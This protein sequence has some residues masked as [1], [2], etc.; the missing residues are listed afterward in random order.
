MGDGVDERTATGRIKIFIGPPK[1]P[2][3]NEEVDM[4]GMFVSKRTP[5]DILTY[6]DLG[7]DKYRHLFLHIDF[8]NRIKSYAD[9]NGKRYWANCL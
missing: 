6:A 9:F 8:K 7:N 1:S 3:L 2:D 5:S 4:K